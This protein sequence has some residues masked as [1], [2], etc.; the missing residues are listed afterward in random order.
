MRRLLPSLFLALLGAGPAA[1]QR[2]AAE[3]EAY[4]ITTLRT[5][6][7]TLFEVGAVELLPDRKIA[8]ATRRGEVWIAS[9]GYEGAAPEWTLFARYLHEPLG[10]SWH[11]G[12]LYAVQRP[13]VT[14]MKDEDGDGRA[15]VFE[16][17][18]DGWGIKGDYH[19]YAFGSRHDAEGNLWVVLCLT[20]SF[21]AEAL[22]RGWVLRVTPEGEVLPTAC[23]V[24]SP[25]GIGFGPRGEVFYC[26]NQGAW[27]GSSSLKHVRIGS[28]QGNPN[29]NAYFPFTGGAIGE[30]P[31]F[32]TTV[33]SRTVTER[34]NLPT[35]VPPAAMLPHG[36][37][38]QSPTGIALI[39]NDAFGPFRG[40]LLV[41][42][43]TF[44]QVQRVFLE[45][46]NGVWQGAAFPFLSGFRSGNIAVRLDADG[47]LFTGG[48]NRGWGAR[49]G[50]EEA[51]ERV[52]WSGK[53]PFE[54]K[55]M[56]ALGDGFRLVFTEPTDAATAVD[57]SF[58]M[59]AYTYIYQPGYG[60]PEVDALTPRVRVSA[61]SA[62]GLTVDLQVEPLTR[63]HVHELS[64]SGVRDRAGQP[65]VHSVGYYTLNEIPSR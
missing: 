20:G 11:D 38:G 4:P 45:E 55:E 8:V 59:K 16:C 25:G 43:Q 53:T 51:L 50:Q 7:D 58:A 33:G 61:V 32:P 15:D 31:P 5:P 3:A 18:S 12:W 29:G 35:Y 24:R 17:V 19:E 28:F 42:E 6:P 26:D 22:Y 65:L 21:T 13:E 44:S 52:R 48:S 10:L 40:Q 63:G 62:D 54:V 56:R 60:S 47:T 39:E 23:G 64:L 36:K 14:R 30:E 2:P 27:N 49:G 37:L 9:G 41:G 46:V 57:S 1:A 34:A